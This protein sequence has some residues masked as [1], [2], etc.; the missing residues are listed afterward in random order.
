MSAPKYAIRCD[1]EGVGGVVSYDQAEPGRP[2]YGAARAWFNAELGALL[3]G[4]RAGGAGEIVVYDE[5][6]AGRNI[7]L[8]AL[9]ASVYAVCGK[10]PYRADWAGGLDASCA[11]LILHGLHAR[12]GAGTL[13]CH[14]YE[15][16]IA[17]LT[18]NGTRVG[19]IGMETAIAGDWDVPLVLI[20]ADSAGVAEAQALR[21]GVVGLAVK[22]SQ[23]LT[24]AVCPAG[25]EVLDH[26]FQAAE[27]LVQHPPGVA[28]WRV[29]AADLTI[30]FAEGAYLD[31]LRRDFAHWLA[32]PTTMRLTGASATAV[33]ADYWQRKLAVQAALNGGAR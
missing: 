29:G 28:P 27:A 23:G 24:G 19:E 10:P 30:E 26:L 1:L 21:P 2:E 8:A 7:D 9:P 31:A 3:A 4:L 5:H 17:A 18:L 20:S 14:T 15:H 12:A 6:C 22:E 11:G 33:W 25:D 32:T 16:D 13:L